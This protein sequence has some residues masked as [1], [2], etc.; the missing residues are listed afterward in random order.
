[1]D[2]EAGMGYEGKDGKS[3][4]RLDWKQGKISGTVYRTHAYSSALNSILI[5]LH[6]CHIQ[7][8]AQTLLA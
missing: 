6:P 4:D 1:M 2:D 7:M 3:D 8:A 5:L